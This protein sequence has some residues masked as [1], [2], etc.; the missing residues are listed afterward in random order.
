MAV[1]SA[2]A[3]SMFAA[4]MEEHFHDAAAL[5]GLRLDVIHV[6]DAQR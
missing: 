1:I 4:R 2:M 5:H 6:G 3:T